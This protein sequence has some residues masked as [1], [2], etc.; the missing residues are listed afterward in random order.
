[1]LINYLPGA[2]LFL[3]DDRFSAA[4]RLFQEIDIIS[5]EESVLMEI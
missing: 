1:M 2:G 5:P 4:P 3:R